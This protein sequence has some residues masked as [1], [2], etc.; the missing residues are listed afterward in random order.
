MPLA[1]FPSVESCL[2]LQAKDSSMEI[3][4][5]YMVVA[6]DYHV[7]TSD[8]DCIFDLSKETSAKELRMVSLMRR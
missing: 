2:G 7:D 6:F 3:K 4:D 8:T 1:P 5:G